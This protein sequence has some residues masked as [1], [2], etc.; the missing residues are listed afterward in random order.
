MRRLLLACDFAFGLALALLPG[1][2]LAA[3][4]KE[5]PANHGCDES[6]WRLVIE[7]EQY[8]VCALAEER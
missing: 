7:E 4:D 1:T 5:P 8:K 2:A 3:R 6:E